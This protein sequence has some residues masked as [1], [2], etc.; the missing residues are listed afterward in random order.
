MQNNPPEI[1][2]IE[3]SPGTIFVGS[4]I[5][6]KVIADDPDGDSLNYEWTAAE[7]SFADKNA[8]DTE[9]IVPGN[10]GSYQITV[11]VSDGN[12]GTNEKTKQ[13]IVSP[14]PQTQ[15]TMEVPRDENGFIVKDIK[16][17]II[18]NLI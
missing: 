7:V 12:G 2:E 10:P 18:N 5:D 15:Q 16:C 8:N 4:T 1:T 9:Y 14:P 17:T 3:I 6:V 11:Q 13:I